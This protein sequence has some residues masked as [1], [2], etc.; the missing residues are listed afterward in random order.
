MVGE[1]QLARLLEQ[2]TP[3]LDA[4]LFVFC[5]I[6]PQKLKQYEIQQPS[7][8]TDIQQAAIAVFR[9]AEGL[10]LILPQAIA[11]AYELPTTYP[12]RRITLAIHSSL[13]AV[14]FLATVTSQLAKHDISVNPVSAYF[15]DHLFVPPDRTDEAMTVLI[16]MQVQA[17]ISAQTSTE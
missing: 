6:A 10:S 14:G 15:H 3:N 11:Q 12:C 5:T 1:R 8:L 2:M 13:D 4:E 9:E 7:V 17:A 16:Q